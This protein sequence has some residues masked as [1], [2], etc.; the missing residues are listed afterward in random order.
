[1]TK[2]SIVI[3][4]VIKIQGQAMK[5]SEAQEIVRQAQGHSYSWLK[6]WGLS[7]IRE[8]IRTIYNRKSA[9]KADLEYAE[10]LDRKIRRK[11]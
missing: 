3:T 2:L 9:T 10:E 5:L 6:A 11:W 7:Y 1:M 4:F 8:A